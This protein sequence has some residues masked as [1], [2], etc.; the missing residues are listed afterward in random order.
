M[1][2]T[3]RSARLSDRAG[4]A[5]WL[6][7]ALLCGLGLVWPARALAQDAQP[8]ELTWD[9]PDGCPSSA[10]VLARVRQLAGP[11]KT[12]GSELRAEATISQPSDGQLHL[13]LVIHAGNLVGVRNIDGTSCKDLAGAA[14]VAL[15]LLLSSEEPLSERELTGPATTETPT[16]SAKPSDVERTNPENPAPSV[17]PPPPAPKPS[18]SPASSTEATPP[19]P[20]RGL[21]LLPFGAL[22]VGPLRQPS[23]GLGLAAGASF[24]R[25]RVLAEGTL[26]SRQH[27][28]ATN[29][30]DEYGADLARFSIGLRGCRNLSSGRFELAPCLMASLQHLSARGNGAH[31]TPLSNDATWIA[32]GVGLR[33]GVRVAPWLR[34]VAGVDGEVETSRPEIGIADIGSVERLLPVA[35]TITVGPEWIL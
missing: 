31:V 20:L 14:A 34:L 30:L 7:P 26:W 4:T 35:A 3:S 33:L 10:A 12:T 28:T 25:W 18:N 1:W 32:A 24:E 5:L 29:L 9:A 19:R 23:L 11:T 22:S 13:R 6:I 17:A 8:V 21:L 27:A 15:A 2:T 16:N